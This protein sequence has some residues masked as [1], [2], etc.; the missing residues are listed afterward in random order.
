MIKAATTLGILALSSA[1]L[2]A[3]HAQPG[4]A[5]WPA[6]PLKMVV[7]YPPGG[8]TDAIARFV[9]QPMSKALGQPVLVENRP[10]ANGVIAVDAVAHAPAD[11][12]TLLLAPVTQLAIVPRLMK[13][14]YDPA[15]DF[16]PISIVA[17]N[18]FVLTVGAAFPAKTLAEFVEYAR[19]RKGALQYASSGEGSLPH[20][21]GV[22][23]F[24]RA[25]VELTHVPYKGNAQIMADVLGG[26][27]PAYFANLSEVLPHANKGTLRFLAQTGETRAPQL[28]DVPTIAE[29]GYPGFRSLT[30]NGLLAPTGT[31]QAVVDRLAGLVAAATHD[32]EIAG[33]MQAAGLI[34]VGDTPSQFAE[35][36]RADLK[37]WAKTVKLF[38]ARL[39]D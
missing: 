2:P 12:Y 38:G 19:S 17:T 35:T 7:P 6:R 34:P 30:W 8:N 26:H 18:P 20:L 37:S 24:S 13:T 31:P 3:A 33:R 9:A 16:A 4:G 5:A 11:G 14:N 39:A 22:Q 10:G 28:P 1:L 29:Q 23:L 27:V 21:T 15:T 36:L 25:G 32:P